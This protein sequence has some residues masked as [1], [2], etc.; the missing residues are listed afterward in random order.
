MF[1]LLLFTLG[2]LAHSFL[3]LHYFYL[4]YK[5]RLLPFFF[6]GA[7]SIPFAWIALFFA[8]GHSQT[9]S[10][11]DE[12]I[13]RVAFL[14]LVLFVFLFFLSVAYPTIFT[15]YNHPAFLVLSE[16]AAL[17]FIILIV[18]NDPDMLTD[19]PSIFEEHEILS[20]MAIVL[21]LVVIGAILG[22]WAAWKAYTGHL[23]ILAWICLSLS[24]GTIVGGAL[25]LV[26]QMDI[27]GLA[28]IAFFEALGTVFLMSSLRFKIISAMYPVYRSTEGIPQFSVQATEKESEMLPKFSIA[29]F[30]FSEVGP[31]LYEGRGPLFDTANIETVRLA[32]KLGVFY[33]TLYGTTADRQYDLFR[34][35]LIFGPL[36]V[37]GHPSLRSF[38]CGFRVEDPNSSDPRLENETLGIF[39]VFVPA[40]FCHSIEAYQF[41]NEIEVLCQT[42]EHLDDLAPAIEDLAQKYASG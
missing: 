27:I 38:A 30:I 12:L 16:L 14:M 13:S 1:H 37:Y 34:H 18:L 6:L 29:A 10:E 36:P 17:V 15:R 11:F 40:S 23:D 24:I 4:F 5:H 42:F 39:S 35:S 22:P 8:L 26:F 7:I 25:V 9:G 32:P 21:F 33:F 31:K 41:Q 3:G 20:K 2:V 19:H 28:I